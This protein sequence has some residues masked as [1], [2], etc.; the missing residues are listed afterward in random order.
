[1]TVCAAAVLAAGCTDP[2][3]LVPSDNDGEIAVTFDI[4]P[5]VQESV[6][7]ATRA[8]VDENA[9][10]DLQLLLIGA[11]GRRYF[12]E[13]GN[14]KFVAASVRRGVYDV[15]AVANSAVR[16]NAVRQSEL[17]TLAAPYREGD[18][19]LAMS[20]SGKADFS[21]GQPS[22]Y[23]IRLTRTVAKLR[24]NIQT[25]TGVAIKSM[26]LCNVPTGA[27]M[28]SGGAVNLPTG[29]VGLAPDSRAFSV[30]LP[31]LLAGSVGSI[32]DQRGRTRQNAPEMAAYLK[33]TG[34]LA[35]RSVVEYRVY[36]GSNADDD[37]NLRRNNDYR[38]EI[39]IVSDWSTDLRISAYRAEHTIP[40]TRTPN[41]YVG[42]YEIVYLK[43]SFVTND[44]ETHPRIHYRYNFTGYEP[45]KLYVDKTEITDAGYSGTLESGQTHTLNLYNKAENFNESNHRV[46]YTLTFT[47]TFGA[48]TVYTGELK[49]VNRFTA[50]VPNDG[51]VPRAEVVFPDVLCTR[52]VDNR[53]YTDYEAFYLG[54]SIRMDVVA[55]RAGY[56]F[57]GWYTYLDYKKL[58]SN[59]SSI[60][61]TYAGKSSALYV[62]V[63]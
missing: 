7:G 8:V 48:T 36:L 19:A 25:A 21:D 53:N 49:Y 37:F 39:N 17:S 2:E 38:I 42:H 18:T 60:V 28:F 55:V 46:G 33:I 27:A 3:I 1:M 59:S 58:I 61:W 56:S 30:Y 5:T 32:A 43:P 31:E 20:F 16:L 35:D 47:D 44:P 13:P 40:P 29:V 62:R 22:A 52:R 4:A 6:T 50:Y 12:F 15:Y 14:E 10:A 26:S 11:D 9:I 51:G 54:T 34:E 24:F 57:N 41:G 63:E 23:Y 45:G